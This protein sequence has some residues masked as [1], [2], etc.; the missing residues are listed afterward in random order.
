[1]VEEKYCQT[2]GREI[3]EGTRTTFEIMN[4]INSML[5]LNVWIKGKRID[6]LKLEEGIKK[7]QVAQ[8]N[9]KGDKNVRD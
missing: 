8:L 9:D 1:M 2:C 5:G 7:C 3:R 4:N 6:M